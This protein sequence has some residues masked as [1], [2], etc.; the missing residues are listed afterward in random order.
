MVCVVLCV[1]MLCVVY[2]WLCVVVSCWRVHVVL[3]VVVS[4]WRVH[5]VL[6]VHVVLWC[7]CVCCVFCVVCLWGVWC[8]VFCVCVHVVL[9]KLGTRKT[10]LCVRSK[11]LRVYGEDVSVCTGNRP[12]CLGHSGLLP[13]HTETSSPYTRR[14]FERTHRGVFIS[15][16]ILFSFLRFSF[17]PSPLLFSCLVSLL[18]CLFLF[19][20]FSFLFSLFSFLF[21]LSL[22]LSLSLFFIARTE[23]R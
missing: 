1:Y 21:S 3:C 13:V 17:S 11:R 6:S 12:E 5:V 4:C 14:R 9:V 15:S 18:T 8:V 20:F 10:P 2:M 7:V 22:S 23:T 19:F 16:S